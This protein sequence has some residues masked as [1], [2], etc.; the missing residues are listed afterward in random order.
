M[1]CVSHGARAGLRSQGH[2]QAPQATSIYELPFCNFRA[3]QPL[4]GA[5]LLTRQGG[6]A[7]VKELLTHRGL[8]AAYSRSGL[9]TEGFGQLILGAACRRRALGGWVQVF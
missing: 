6:T 7:C 9:P 3:A 1:H 5:P 4:L 8:R 2:T